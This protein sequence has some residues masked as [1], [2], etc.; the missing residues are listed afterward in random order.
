MIVGSHNHE[1]TRFCLWTYLDDENAIKVSRVNDSVW[2]LPLTILW[3][4]IF[5]IVWNNNDN[6]FCNYGKNLPDFLFMESRV[7]IW[8]LI[9]LQILELS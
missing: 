4:K 8:I 5:Q 6:R 1:N 3:V 2:G 9:P 7:T